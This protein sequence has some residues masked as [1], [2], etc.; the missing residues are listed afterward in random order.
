[1]SL[2]LFAVCVRFPPSFFVLFK[3]IFFLIYSVFPHWTRG[4]GCC[5]LIVG[6]GV[7]KLLIL[8]VQVWWA[9]QHL[10]TVP[11][12]WFPFPADYKLVCYA[13]IIVKSTDLRAT[14]STLQLKLYYCKPQGFVCKSKSFTLRYILIDRI[15]KDTK[16]T[17]KFVS[18]MNLE[19]IKVPQFEINYG[20]KEL[21]DCFWTFLIQTWIHLHSCL[22]TYY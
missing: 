4:A 8:W 3:G 16:L 21:R 15:Q 22:T 11:R 9:G 5:S 19:Y 13:V 1:M 6:S 14:L 2:G 12:C 10:N 7:S 20:K 18:L 17:Q